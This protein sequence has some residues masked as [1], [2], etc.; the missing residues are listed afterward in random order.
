MVQTIWCVQYICHSGSAPLLYHMPE[1]I[2]WQTHQL[3]STW[4]TYTH[5]NMPARCHQPYAL[6]LGQSLQNRPT[7][8]RCMHRC[9]SFLF[10]VQR[11]RCFH[12]HPVQTSSSLLSM[13][14]FLSAIPPYLP[15]ATNTH[16]PFYKPIRHSHPPTVACRQSSPYI[17]ID[18][19]VQKAEY[20]T[21]GIADPFQYH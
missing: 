21:C 12:S 5:G 10:S 11:T 15:D 9:I 16:Y 2:P 6:F 4:Y 17:Y 20:R 14:P 3:V 8:F 1:D 7:A 19:Q 18:T 13:H